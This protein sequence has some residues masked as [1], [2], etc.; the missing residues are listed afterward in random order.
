MNLITAAKS[1]F[2]GQKM[3]VNVSLYQKIPQHVSFLHSKMVNFQRKIS[4]RA[5]PSSNLGQSL[6][7]TL[8][9]GVQIVIGVELIAAHSI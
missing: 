8:R 9:Q 7:E 4:H 2:K 1:T 5:A 3:K 6:T